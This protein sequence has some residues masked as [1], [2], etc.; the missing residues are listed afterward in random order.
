MGAGGPLGARGHGGAAVAVQPVSGG[1]LPEELFWRGYLQPVLDARVGTTRTFLGVVHNGG[2]LLAT[3]LFALG[4]VMGGAG[5]M[6]LGTVSRASCLGPSHGPCG[7]AG[8]GLES[9]HAL[10]AHFVVHARPRPSVHLALR[11]GD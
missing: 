6:A 7:I 2:T 10:R 1:R 8:M 5:P 3:A 9:V 11:A 4:H